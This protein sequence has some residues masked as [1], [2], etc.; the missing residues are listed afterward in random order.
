MSGDPALIAWLGVTKARTLHDVAADLAA[1]GHHDAAE[2]V[3]KRARALASGDV[4]PF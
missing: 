2:L 4:S 1:A 3:S